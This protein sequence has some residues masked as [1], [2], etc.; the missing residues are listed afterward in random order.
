MSNSSDDG[1]TR[2]ELLQGAGALAIGATLSGCEPAGKTMA[3]PASSL[4]E[5]SS[6]GTL[7]AKNIH[8]LMTIDDQ[9][10]RFWA[11]Q[12]SDRGLT[13]PQGS[14]LSLAGGSGASSSR[15]IA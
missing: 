7:L 14:R 6:G 11:A 3:P 5:K 4:E 8:T 2:P 10:E 9:I 12:P 15:Y 1:V 13:K